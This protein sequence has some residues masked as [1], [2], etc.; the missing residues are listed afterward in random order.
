MVH[1]REVEAVAEGG[2]A[3]GVARRHGRRRAEDPVL[4][5]D[6]PAGRV[7]DGVRE[8][9]RVRSAGALLDHG[10]SELL[11][12]LHRPDA[13]ADDGA[14]S[15]SV[16]VRQLEPR[17]REREPRGDDREQAEPVD[18]LALLHVE[19]SGCVEVDAAELDTV[20]RA[21]APPPCRVCVVQGRRIRA[22]RAQGRQPGDHHAV[23][24]PVRRAAPSGS[25][26]GEENRRVGAAEGEVVR[27]RDVDLHLARLVRHVVE[28]A[29]GIRLR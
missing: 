14:D 6:L 16:V 10:R 9:G 20:L 3:G 23:D 25:P 21:R 11:H 12:A 27:Q 18:A 15:R 8:D 22:G 24:V 5:R 19:R 13:G 4:D 28:V 17:V 1:R 7:V 29:L 2:S 26:A